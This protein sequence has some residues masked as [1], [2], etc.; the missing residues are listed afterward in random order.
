M[1]FLIH[2]ILFTLFLIPQARA[3]DADK[4]FDAGTA[5]AAQSALK[6][7]GENKGALKS[8][9]PTLYLSNQSL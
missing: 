6:A 4:P 5:A 2:I 7:L 1:K 8:F 3:W 9:L